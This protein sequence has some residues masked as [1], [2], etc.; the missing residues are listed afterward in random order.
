MTEYFGISSFHRTKICAQVS[1]GLVIC[2]PAGSPEADDFPI[3]G[4]VLPQR[5]DLLFLVVNAQRRTASTWMPSLP[6]F[7]PPKVV[8]P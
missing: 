1:S 6:S 7:L 2:A 8:K 4:F 5:A 3:I